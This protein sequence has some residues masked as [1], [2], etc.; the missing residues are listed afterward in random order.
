L[1][2]PFLA[3]VCCPRKGV[4]TMLRKLSLIAALTAALA[5][6]ADALAR[7]GVRGA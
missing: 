4:V 2:P 7:G 5:F 3:W 6:P 1:G